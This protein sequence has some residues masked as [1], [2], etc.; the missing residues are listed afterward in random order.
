MT[1]RKRVLIGLALL[2]MTVLTTTMITST[3]TMIFAK[4]EHASD[5][6][7]K[8]ST[9]TTTD[10][11]S[12]GDITS[13]QAKSDQPSRVGN[14]DTQTSKNGADKG[15]T[16]TDPT[17][18]SQTDN[19]DCKTTVKADCFGKVIQERAQEHKTDPSAGNLGSHASDPVPENPGHETPREGI[20]NQDQGHPAAHGAFN[21]QFD[22]KDEQN[23]IN[24]C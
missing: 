3:P 15:G 12:N 6:S 22:P 24:N 5:H 8:T 18:C 9:T 1:E 2:V 21:S 20:G 19:P 17:L 14:H 7:T 10:Q 4:S 23:V 13:D 16:V 11:S